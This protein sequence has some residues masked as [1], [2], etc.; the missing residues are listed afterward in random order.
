MNKRISHPLLTIKSQNFSIPALGNYQNKNKC[1]ICSTFNL[2][3]TLKQIF[4]TL[5]LSLLSLQLAAQPWVDSPNPMAQFYK[6]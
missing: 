2:P 4:T 1:F 6:E 5:A 3:N